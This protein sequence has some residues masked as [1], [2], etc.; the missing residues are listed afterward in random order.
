MTI[1]YLVIRSSFS[2]PLESS[3][4]STNSDYKT[5]EIYDQ[6]LTESTLRGEVSETL[7]EPCPET[8]I[9]ALDAFRGAMAGDSTLSLL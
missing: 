1:L 4:T 3:K 8:S 9:V 5:S 2:F 6:V 7:F